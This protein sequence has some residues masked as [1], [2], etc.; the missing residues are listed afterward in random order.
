MMP[1]LKKKKYKAMWSKNTNSNSTYSKRFIKNNQQEDIWKVKQEYKRRTI[2]VQKEH[3]DYWSIGN[4]RRV[5]TNKQ[6]NNIISIDLEKAFD[7][8]KMDKMM[9]T[10]MKKVYKFGQAEN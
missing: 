10:Y 5:H 6:E 3:G 9:E 1:N 8:V 4:N 7:R 2:W